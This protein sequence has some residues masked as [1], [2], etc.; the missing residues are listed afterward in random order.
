MPFALHLGQKHFVSVVLTGPDAPRRESVH[1]QEFKGRHL[2]GEGKQIRLVGRLAVAAGS[3]TTRP[4][5]EVEEIGEFQRTGV[6]PILRLIDDEDFDELHHRLNETNER[7]M[8]TGWEPPVW[9]WMRVR[10]WFILWTNRHHLS[11]PAAYNKVRLYGPRQWLVMF[12]WPDRIEP[13]RLR[14]ID[15][16][17]RRKVA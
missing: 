5:E 12:P 8:R 6:D 15:V 16:V 10:E 11:A 4:P 3:W 13:V 9:H 2:Y 7:M 14:L 1:M 17:Q